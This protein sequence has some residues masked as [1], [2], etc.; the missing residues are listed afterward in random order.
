M[1]LD[2]PQIYALERPEPSL[3]KYYGLM[4]LLGGPFFF[5]ILL[6]LY[7]RYQ[8]LRYRFD[9]E[10]VSMRWGVLFRR[11]INLTYAR[12]QDIHLENNVVER[13]LG[14]A[15]IKIQTAS[16][17]SKAEMTIEGIED[18]E[19][20]R[21]FLYSR[22]RGH[23]KPTR[24]ADTTVGSA[25]PGSAGIDAQGM[26]AL[27]ATLRAVVDEVRDLRRAVER[28]AGAQHEAD[29]GSD[30]GDPRA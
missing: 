28:Q 12:I 2:D 27:T 16:G 1:T 20:L 8:T 29:R 24:P 19:V 9:K 5:L 18:F 10:G 3:L 7:F 17:S 21:D 23:R 25:L 15:R 30:G 6:P 22:M 4:S 11:E 13:W 26:A 14:L